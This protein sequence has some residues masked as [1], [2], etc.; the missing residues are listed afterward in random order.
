MFVEVESRGHD[1]SRIIKTTKEYGNIPR[2][3]E[4][5]SALSATR[6]VD[7]TS[8]LLRRSKYGETERI[9]PLISLEHLVSSLSSF[10]ATVPHDIIYSL[11][12]IARDTNPVTAIEQSPQIVTPRVDFDS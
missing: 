3:F 1:P 2:F 6:L 12:A 9:E 7:A 8:N 11:L 5:V 10:E 4:H